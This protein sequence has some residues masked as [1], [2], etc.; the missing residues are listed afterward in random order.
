MSKHFAP[1]ARKT[2]LKPSRI[3]RQPV[4]LVP[5]APAAA[6]RKPVR[7]SD[8]EQMWF[9]VTGVLI[10]AAAIVVLTVAAAIFTFTRDDRA[11][12]QGPR[13]AQC[14][15]ANGSDC[16]QDGD[17]I[18]VGGQRVEIAGIVAPAIQG[19]RCDAERDKGIEA[20]MGLASLLNR[21]QVTVSPPARDT[22]GRLAQN[23]QVNGTDVGQS[24]INLGLA[25]PDDGSN[26]GWC[27]A[28]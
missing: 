5:D 1:P 18:T 4:K 9:G 24:M 8:S 14:Y 6:T 19:A 21:G 3:R 22:S 23:V 20:A 27:S 16:V 12:A 25:R 11:A 15:N 10:F 26:R 28:S 13:F 17:T 7:L 2:P